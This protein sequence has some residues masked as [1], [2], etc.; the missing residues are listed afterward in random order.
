MV[1]RGIPALHFQINGPRHG[2]AHQNGSQ[3]VERDKLQHQAAFVALQHQDGGVEHTESDGKPQKAVRGDPLVL[4]QEQQAADRRT[5]D[6]DD[7]GVNHIGGHGIAQ[8]NRM[9][10]RLG[11]QR[12][13][14]GE[15]EDVEQG[16]AQRGQRDGAL[17][18]VKTVDEKTHVRLLSDSC[19]TGSQSRE[20]RQKKAAGG[21]SARRFSDQNR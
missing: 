1:E 14:H 15:N 12:V 6:G 5:D 11:E 21:N 2:I 20:Q 13:A 10:Q 4:Q 16:R 3:T 7:Q 17:S 18:A 9:I 19:Q 8:R